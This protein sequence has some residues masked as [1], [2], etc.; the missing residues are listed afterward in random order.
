MD[1]TIYDFPDI[2]MQLREKDLEALKGLIRL[3]ESG[4]PFWQRINA[5]QIILRIGLNV[6]GE[7]SRFMED[8]KYV[9]AAT[10]RTEYSGATEDLHQA[11][12]WCYA[13][14]LQR[15]EERQKSIAPK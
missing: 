12:D 8:G 15:K 11:M 3:V 1:Y 9:Y 7:I 14:H 6:K 2:N 5:N 13:M 4:Q 10:T